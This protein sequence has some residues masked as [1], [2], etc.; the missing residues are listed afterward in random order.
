MRKSILDVN[1]EIPFKN[2]TLTYG[3][4]NSVHHGH[5]RYLKHAASR[6]NKL[7]VAMLP[8]TSKGSKNLYQFNQK[9]RAE[10]LSSFNFID[11]IILLD[12]EENSL[13]NVIKKIEPNLLVL[14]KE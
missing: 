5:I 8:D 6:G 1:D 4:F 7:I 3:H 13:L 14:G 9:E 2:C 12:D 10:S 11:G